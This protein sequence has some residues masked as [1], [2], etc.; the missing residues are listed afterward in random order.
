MFVERGTIVR[1]LDA[2]RNVVLDW[3]VELEQQGI[4]GEG[5]S[6]TM[7]EKADAAAPAMNV[8]NF[9]DTVHGS[10]FQQG[11]TNAKQAISKGRWTNSVREV[12]AELRTKLRR[13]D[14]EELRAR[15]LQAEVATA[16][17]QLESPEPKRSILAE[18]L[19]SARRI[20][21]GAGG[22]LAAQLATKLASLPF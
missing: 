4:L 17:A 14:I 2:V 9:F 21:E 20:L 5:L 18:C 12:V 15:E 8:D 16:E 11:N 7:Q 10:Q 1:A 22:S 19:G 6:F 3:A 13:L